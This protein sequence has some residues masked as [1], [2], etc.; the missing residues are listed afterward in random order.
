[1]NIRVGTKLSINLEGQEEHITVKYVGEKEGQHIVLTF[2]D[3]RTELTD[4]LKDLSDVGVQYFENGIRYEFKSRVIDLPE[5]PLDL[6][7][8][9]YPSEVYSIDNRQLDRINCLVSAKVKNQV[10]D[11]TQSVDGVIANINKTGCQCSLTEE[12][13]SD[14]SFSMG[15]QV[16]LKCQF[17]G[18]VGEQSAEGKIVRIQKQGKDIILGINFNEEIWWVPPYDLK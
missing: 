10:F 7:V 8:M 18:L 5:E 2:P 6:I 14:I 11:D 17:P 13:G 12:E 15:D 1:M 9:E 16:V 3:K 4:K